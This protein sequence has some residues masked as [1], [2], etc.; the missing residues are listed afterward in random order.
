MEL[1]RTARRAPVQLRQA[2]S[3]APSDTAALSSGVGCLRAMNLIALLSLVLQGTGCT[4]DSADNEKREFIESL[5][6]R[7][8]TG[9]CGDESSYR[10]CLG[11]SRE[12]CTTELASLQAECADSHLAD[13]P[14]PLTG[15]EFRNSIG[16]HT[17][18]WSQCV[19]NLHLETHLETDEKI[20]ECMMHT[21]RNRRL[22]GR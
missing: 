1:E 5:K 12:Q 8:I 7:M 11:I 14:Y 13:L 3:V 18:K 10:T 16:A 19:A 15:E 20:A 6:I 17:L 9:A 2:G 4:L 22:P 21:E